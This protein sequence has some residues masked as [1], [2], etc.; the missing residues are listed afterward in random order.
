[1]KCILVLK[2]VE[3]QTVKFYKLVT[4]VKNGNTCLFIKQKNDTSAAFTSTDR[5][6]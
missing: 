3:R 5:I 6:L 2:I 4:E 1:M